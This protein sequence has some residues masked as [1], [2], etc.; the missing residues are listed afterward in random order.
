MREIK[1]RA[2]DESQ[3]AMFPAG[4][5]PDGFTFT[6]L[7]GSKSIIRK[8][9]ILMQFTGLK[10][11]NGKDIYEGDILKNIAEEDN[12]ISIQ[13]DTSGACWHFNEIDIAFDDG[14]GRGDWS[15]TLG[16]SKNCVVIGNI[17]EGGVK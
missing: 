13:W 15:F 11:K 16:V 3:K 14:V 9:I 7:S 6:M 1:F 8:E 10:D 4:I 5:T 2:W 17:Y 12:K